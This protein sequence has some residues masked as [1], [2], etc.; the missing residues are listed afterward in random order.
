MVKATVTLEQAKVVY[1]ARESE[2]CK[3]ALKIC[4]KFDILVVCPRPDS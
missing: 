2:F 1:H 3:K 4:S